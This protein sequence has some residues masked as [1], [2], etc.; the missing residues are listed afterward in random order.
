MKKLSIFWVTALLLMGAFWSCTDE[1]KELIGV[2]IVDKYD[3]SF[4]INDEGVTSTS[5]SFEV[6][7]TDKKTPYVCLYVDKTVI[8]KVPKHDLPAFLVKELKKNAQANSK[9]WEEYLSG[10]AITG[11]TKKTISNLLPG[12]MYELVVFGVKDNR[13]SQSATY[14][15]FE[16][17]KAD[18]VKM[19]FDV[20]ATPVKPTEIHIDVKPSLQNVKWYFCSFPKASYDR[21]KAMGMNDSQIALSYLN[22]EVKN[23]LMYNPNP[24]DELLQKFINSKFYEG[25]QKLVIRGRTIKADTEYVYLSTGVFL[26]ADKEI[27]FISETTFGTF[28]TPKVQQKDVT[29]DM[30]VENITQTTASVYIKPSDPTLPIV[31]R[32]GVLNDALQAMTPEEHAKYIIDTN[33][34]ISF[35]AFPQTVSYPTYKIMPDS[36]HFLIVFG[37]EG[38]VST[39]VQR[40]EFDP[41]KAGDPMQTD[42]TVDLL[43]SSSDKVKL[44]VTPSESSVYYLPLLYPDTENKE[45]VKGK[46]IANFR[47]TLEQTKGGF[48]PH[49][50]LWDIIGQ[51]CD[52]GAGEFEWKKMKPGTKYTL[53]ILTFNKTGIASDKY[54]KQSYLTV[55][56]LSQ[57]TVDGVE[58]MGVFDGDEEAGT[59][60]NQPDMVKN[61]AIMVMKYKVSAG[62]HEAYSAASEDMSNVDELDPAVLSDADIL[63]NASLPWTK[64]KLKAPYL[65][66]VVKWDTPQI[67]FSY[68]LTAKMERGPI[69]RA[70]LKTATKADKKPISELKKIYDESKAT[71]AAAV[72][73]RNLIEAMSLVWKPVQASSIEAYLPHTS[74]KPAL[75]SAV[76]GDVEGDVEKQVIEIPV[77]HTVK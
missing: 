36:K 59:I 63:N 41:L 69:A 55:P 12:N 43:Y 68:G 77:V 11:N 7:P 76:V 6:I 30:K 25:D 31:W 50:T 27:V 54:F 26:T 67:S 66:L 4:T 71:P 3:I 2:D 24:S 42:F 47:R 48:N 40:M 51:S 46:L 5:Y 57:E 58:I 65:F 22:E 28:T 75:R 60:F 18:F 23:F 70:S 44:K 52:L 14:K 29:F 16:T 38:G 34:Y 64:M 17:L 37:Y 13:L 21:A 19:T 10:I 53:M 61:K 35:E 62:V 15:F 72:Y 74:D 73:A 8:D 1:K 49:A 56:G 20:T 45:S 32:C 39:K 9:T 33:P